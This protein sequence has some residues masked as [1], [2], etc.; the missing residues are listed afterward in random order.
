MNK[1][2]TTLDNLAR[3]INEGFETTASKEAIAA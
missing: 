1:N 2:V 3:M